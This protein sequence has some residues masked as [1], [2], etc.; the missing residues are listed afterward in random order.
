MSAGCTLAG[1]R[2]DFQ[3]TV[4]GLP[5]SGHAVIEFEAYAVLYHVPFD[6]A[7]HFRIERGHDLVELLDQRHFETAMDQVFHHLEAD[8]SA[9]D[10]HRALRFRHRLGSRVRIHSG[11]ILRAPVKPLAYAPG[12]RN[13]SH[14]EDSRKIDAGQRRTDRR[15]PGRQHELVV[16]LGGDLAGRVVL[17]F[18]GF[19]FGRDA[20]H[21]ALRPAIDGELRAERLFRRHQEARLF[22]DRA[23]DMVRQSAVRVRN[24]RPALD[25]EDLG[26]F[27][28]PAQ[29]R[30]TRRAAGHSAN[31]DNLHLFSPPFG[32]HTHCPLSCF[33]CFVDPA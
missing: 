19:L 25:H 20:D 9:A 28:H 30:R 17:E 16:F 4:R 10:H 33:S 7:R 29:A 18:H 23:S 11:P 24:V 3:R 21:L 13:G 14:R 8:E 22:F 5:E 12:V 27:V 26:F 32:S 6:E 15:R 31:D 2:E 1:T